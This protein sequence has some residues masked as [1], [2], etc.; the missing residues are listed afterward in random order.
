MAPKAKLSVPLQLIAAVPG[1]YT[2]PA[3][4]AYLYYTDEH[5]SFAG[6]IAFTVTR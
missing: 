5:R 2:G 3:S 4:Q 1:K 6:P